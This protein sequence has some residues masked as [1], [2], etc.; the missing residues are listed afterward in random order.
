MKNLRIFFFTLTALVLVLGLS[1]LGYL[2]YQ[3]TRQPNE[4]P[5]NAVPGNTALIIKLNKAG[6]LLEELNRSNLLWKAL[7]R[8]PGIE[9]V[10]NE[11]HFV[12]SASRKNPKINKILQ[13]YPILI[14]ISLSGRDKF[15][16][17]YLTSVNASNAEST[18]VD[19]VTEMAGNKAILTETPYFTT[20]LHRVQIKG[21]RD[22]FYFSVLKGVFV[23]SFRADLVK[24]AIDRLSLNTPLATSTG[25]RMVEASSGKKVDANV[26]VNYRFFSLVLSQITRDDVLPD[27]LKFA[28]FA[29]WSGLDLLIKKDELIFNGITVATDSNQQFLSLFSNQKPQKITIASIMPEQTLYFTAYGW[30]DPT[31]FSE[32]FQNRTPREESFAG[33]QN[34]V[35]TLYE[36]YQV[37]IGDYILPWIGT[38]GGIFVIHDQKAST[39]LSFAAFKCT[40]TLVAA[41]HLRLLSKATGI[42][43]DSIL[44]K[45]H[46]IYKMALPGFF[47]ALFGDLFNKVDP[48][49]FTFLN[50]FAVFSQQLTD[51]EGIIESYQGG[52]TLAKDKVYADFAD[53]FNEKSNVYCFF[54]TRNAI[55]SLQ[56]MLNQELSDQ[57]NP[58]MDS[59]RKFESVAFQYSNMEGLFYSSIVLRYDPNLGKEGPLQW[60]TKLDTTISGHPRIIPITTT[61]DFA[62]AVTDIAHNL[63]LI[64]PD[65]RISWK[66]HI[67]GKF[68]GEIYTIRSP[69]N[70]SLSL[71]FNTDTHLYLIHSN[72]QFS[73]NFPMRFPMH[74]TNGLTLVES[75]KSNKYNI[76]VAFQDNRVYNFTLDGH[77]VSGWTRPDLKEEIN[78]PIQFFNKGG[79]TYYLV[80]GDKGHALIAGKSGS[81]EIRLGSAFI[82]SPNTSF[83]QNKTNKRGI[84]L[85]TNIDGKVLFIQENGQTSEVTLNLFSPDHHFFYEDITGNDH[86]EFIFTDKNRIFYYNRNYKLIYSYAFRRE[87]SVPPFMIRIPGER[88]MIGLVS[89]ETNELFLF[90]DQGNREL[91]SGIRGNTPFDINYLENR[92]QLNLVVGAGKYLRNYRLPKH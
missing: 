54:N 1:W 50:E 89:P 90:D 11:L 53:D 80:T 82:H 39:D 83:Y 78:T 56:K 77:S 32:R 43:M 68:M 15:A 22:A 84:F 5:F 23:A 75:G 9:T 24:K 31:D 30:S 42:R 33:V 49:Y 57:M 38:A 62:V 47:P 66:L 17:L 18:I 7:V 72:G 87:I 12:D 81:T 86:P 13:Q 41:K 21:S 74:A 35:A 76:L 25:F 44:F 40:D 45:G 48:K 26:Y 92:T 60:Q 71:L 59:I 67:M 79:T 65:G 14:S 19:F 73:S 8:F 2:L 55:H 28:Y 61:G 46:R 27:L 51:L 3:R 34:P 52:S 16:A 85:T 10:R 20:Q 58:V 69:G 36:Q 6:N 70:D 88:P 91:E 29:D 63:Y 64:T 4:S 37:N